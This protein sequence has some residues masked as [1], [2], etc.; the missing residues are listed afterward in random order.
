MGRL[1]NIDANVSIDRFNAFDADIPPLHVHEVLFAF[2]PKHSV[3]PLCVL[4]DGNGGRQEVHRT[5]AAGHRPGRFK[6]RIEGDRVW[7]HIHVTA[8]RNKGGR[9]KQVKLLGRPSGA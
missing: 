8:A 1:T 9:L 2:D 5:S 4:T 6:A 7:T 3:T